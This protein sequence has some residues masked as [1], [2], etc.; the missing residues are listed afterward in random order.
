M[1]ADLCYEPRRE[2][3]RLSGRGSPAPGGREGLKEIVRG[4]DGGRTER[5]ETEDGYTR[6]K[7]R[8]GRYLSRRRQDFVDEGGR[9]VQLLIC[10]GGGGGVESARFWVQDR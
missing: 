7:Q 10:S 5:K 9:Q 3:H 6:Q 4:R 8:E 1:N 2:G